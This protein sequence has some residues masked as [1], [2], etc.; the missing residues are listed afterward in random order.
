MR[1]ARTGS[2]ADP[3]RALRS[4]ATL[5]TLTLS[6]VTGSISHTKSATPTCAAHLRVDAV[7][8]LLPLCH[9][10]RQPPPAEAEPTK[11]HAWSTPTG[12]VGIR[13][14]NLATFL[15]ALAGFFPI[16]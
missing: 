7:A 1:A 9:P 10:H 6:A 12:L 3:R 13:S 5:L 2:G 15:E 11:G 14:L 8:D 16:V 4:R